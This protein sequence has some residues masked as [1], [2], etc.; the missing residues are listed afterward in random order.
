MP[1]RLSSSFI[2]ENAEFIPVKFGIGCLHFKLLDVNFGL[3]RPWG[4]NRI[5]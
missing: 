5:S 4:L 2:S 3:Y 1:V